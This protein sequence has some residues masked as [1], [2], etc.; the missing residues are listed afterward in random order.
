MLATSSAWATAVGAIEID[1]RAES[2]VDSQ[3]T[4]RLVRI[5]L[6]DVPVPPAAGQHE[7]L[8]FVRVLS[9]ADGE[10]RVEL[11]ERGVPYGARNVSGVTEAGS[12]LARRVA[13]AAAELARELSDAREDEALLRKQAGERARSAARLERE[14]TL[15]GPRALRRGIAGCWAKGLA[16]L[17]PSLAGELHAYRATRFDVD[18]GFGHGVTFAS[19]PVESLTLGFGPARRVVVARRWDIDLGLR[20]AASVLQ[21]PRARAVDGIAAEHQTWSASAEG[22]V[23]LEPRLSRRVRLVVGLGGGLLLR[24]VP[25]AAENGASKRLAGPFASAEVGFVFTPF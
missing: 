22:R 24:A 13:L 6:A 23:R 11:W 5:E 17:G 3:V 10:L 8:L 16:V 21:F 1:S 12:L 14:R 18:L 20:A 15:D 7:V 19:A 9:A 4:R 25:F 2:L